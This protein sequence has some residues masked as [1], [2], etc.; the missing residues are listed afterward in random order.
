MDKYGILDNLG[1]LLLDETTDS[2]ILITDHIGRR[3][4]SSEMKEAM[5]TL[6][7]RAEYGLMA[8]S[9]LSGLPGGNWANVTEI[10]GAFAVS[11]EL[12]A[13]I[14]SGLVKA[15]LAESQA[16]P[17]GGF[18]LARPAAQVSLAEILRAIERRSGLIDCAPGHGICAVSR[19]CRIRG[20][21]LGVH[22]KVKRV[23]E[24]TSLADLSPSVSEEDHFS[25]ASRKVSKGFSV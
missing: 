16:G 6:S 17:L 1:R 19:Q 23:L 3:L 25:G 15:G 9:Y 14:L 18:R 4:E 20:P 21:M 7:K 5:F 13:K 11:R 22:H 2:Y 24:E 10:A 12:L 8:M